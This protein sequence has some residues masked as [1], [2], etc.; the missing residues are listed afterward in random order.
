M[1]KEIPETRQR[2]NDPGIMAHYS[3]YR[4]DARLNQS[5]GHR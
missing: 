1:V 2:E 4:P 5:I 3:E